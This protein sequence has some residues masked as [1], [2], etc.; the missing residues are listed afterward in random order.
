M[1]HLH[2]E[3]EL[4]MFSMKSVIKTMKT[5]IRVIDYFTLFEFMNMI[6]KYTHD[7]HGQ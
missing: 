5:S 1:Y 3:N 2:I 6:I 7:C 4:P